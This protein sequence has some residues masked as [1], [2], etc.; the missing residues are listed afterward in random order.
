MSCW[1][2]VCRGA[3]SSCAAGPVGGLNGREATAG[4]VVVIAAARGPVGIPPSP[5]GGAVGETVVVLV[6]WRGGSVPQLP[7]PLLRWGKAPPQG[8]PKARGPEGGK[9][10]LPTS[11][12]C[13]AAGVDGCRVVG[14]AGDAMRGAVKFLV[15]LGPVGAR[16]AAGPRGGDLSGATAASGA[17]GFGNSRTGSELLVGVI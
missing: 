12:L 14:G 10:G 1:A 4:D 17:G 7:R 3:L 2:S 9:V 15:A 8:E 13:G 11:R 16:R 5:V 6:T